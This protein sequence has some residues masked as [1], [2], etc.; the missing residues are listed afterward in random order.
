MYD[1]PLNLCRLV[2][3]VLSGDSVF[4]LR[5]H[6]K[7]FVGHAP[8]GP[9]GAAPPKPQLDWGRQEEEK[10]KGDRDR[11]EGVSGKEGREQKGK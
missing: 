11:E 2:S 4:Q 6:Q 8:P 5:M 1:L 10:Q 9:A 7:S 3:I